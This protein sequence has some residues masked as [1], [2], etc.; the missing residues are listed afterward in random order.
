MTVQITSPP[1]YRSWP[2]ARSPQTDLAS[3]GMR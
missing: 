3:S 1:K 2:T